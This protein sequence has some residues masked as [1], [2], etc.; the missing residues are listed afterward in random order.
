MTNDNIFIT[1]AKKPALVDTTK[2]SY[3]KNNIYVQMEDPNA[4]AALK[5]YSSDPITNDAQLG[6]AKQEI[7]NKLISLENGSQITNTY[8]PPPIA[9]ENVVEKATT[10]K[11]AELEKKKGLVGDISKVCSDIVN[12]NLLKELDDLIGLLGWE[13]AFGD[14]KNGL[15][16]NDSI[17]AAMMSCGQAGMKNAMKLAKTSLPFITG[18]GGI[19]SASAIVSTYGGDNIK[20]L[21]SE[22]GSLAGNMDQTTGNIDKFNDLTLDIAGTSYDKF[23]LI[24]TQSTG[25]DSTSLTHMTDDLMTKNPIGDLMDT[26]QINSNMYSTEKSVESCNKGFGIISRLF[27]TVT[28]KDNVKMAKACVY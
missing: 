22:I 21:S 9:F 28:D 14:A 16:G 25:F 11:L 17:L 8:N 24:G 20:G 1:T 12:F 6:A 26:S 23:D 19:E 18:Q 5:T 27:N 4:L 15:P 2:P 7:F 3:G 13:G 10:D